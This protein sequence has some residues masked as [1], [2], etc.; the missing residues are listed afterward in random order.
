MNETKL[1]YEVPTIEDLGDL[2]KLTAHNVAG[3]NT[4]ATFPAGT[5][6]TSLTFSF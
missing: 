4:D 5:P 2:L 6:A 3:P 1:P